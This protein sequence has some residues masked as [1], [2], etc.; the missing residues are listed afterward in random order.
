[1][2][3]F[4]KFSLKN[5]YHLLENFRNHICH[6][7]ARVLNYLKTEEK[8]SKQNGKKEIFEEDQFQIGRKSKS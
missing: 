1:M 6:L 2:F 4:I 3:S 7:L 5:V 8:I